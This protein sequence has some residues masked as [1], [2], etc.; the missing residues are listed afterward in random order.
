MGEI[1]SLD[2]KKIIICLAMFV[3]VAYSTEELP[4]DEIFTKAF[5]P[6]GRNIT[7]TTTRIVEQNPYCLIGLTKYCEFEEVTVVRFFE[8]KKLYDPFP[9]AADLIEIKGYDR[10]DTALIS[11]LGE[12]EVTAYPNLST[13]EEVYFKTMEITYANSLNCKESASLFKILYLNSKLPTESNKT[14]NYSLLKIFTY[15]NVY[16]AHRFNALKNENGYY[17]LDPLLCTAGSFEYCVYSHTRRFYD[18]PTSVAYRG[19][20]Y[21]I[22]KYK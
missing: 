22:E 2:Y 17:I 19:R 18:D 15:D 6:K 4:S 5:Y 8:N 10:E 9:A 12:Q 20:V 13:I 1:E 3:I 16:T 11:F 7:Y 21:K 14:Q